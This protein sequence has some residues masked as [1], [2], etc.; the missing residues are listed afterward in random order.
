MGYT[1]PETVISPKNRWR[2]LELLHNTGEDGWSLAKG[3]WEDNGEFKPVLA[4][5]W[6]GNDSSLGNP[7]SRGNPTWFVIPGELEDS[8]LSALPQLKKTEA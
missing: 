7:Q 1:K 2:F 6:N 5:R 8:V 4:I 3:Q